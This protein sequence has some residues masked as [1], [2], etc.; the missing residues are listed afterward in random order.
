MSPTTFVSAV[1]RSIT[2][3]Q[4]TGP[5]TFNANAAVPFAVALATASK[6]RNEKSPASAGLL[7]REWCLTGP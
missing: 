5:T 1:N 2:P 4:T 6:I 7:L 3:L